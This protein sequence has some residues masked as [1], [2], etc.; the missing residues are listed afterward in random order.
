[1][2]ESTL[3]Q[4]ENHWAIWA[5]LIAVATFGLWAETTRW[6]LRVSGFVV[7][8]GTTFVLANLSIIPSTAP[9]FDLVWSYFVPLAIPLLLFKADIV[10]IVRE[11]GPMLLAYAIGAVG[12][13]LGTLLA[14]KVVPLGEHAWQLAGIFCATYVGGSMNFV[15]TAEAL[16]LH[17]SDLIAAGI[18]AD[19]LIMTLYF[20]LLLTLPTISFL[21]KTFSLRTEEDKEGDAREV[22]TQGSGQEWNALALGKAVA[23]AAVLCA[24]GFALSDLTGIKGTG[25]LFIT[26][27]VVIL[28]T[29]LPRQMGQ[30]VGA[31]QVGTFLM[32][33]FFAVI[34]ASANIGIVMRVGPKLFL[35]A[36][37]ILSVHLTFLLVAGKLLKL[38]LDEL[39]IASNA[40]MGGPTTAAAMAVARKWDALVIPAILCGTLGYAIATFVGVALAHWLR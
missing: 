13:V 25:I 22:Q 38:R 8:I 3:I 19:N 14:F 17:E 34:G 5:I 7:V 10:R 21:R 23:I 6:G 16:Q 37:L 40:N 18:A 28:A 24:V 33:I 2:P 11:A 1:M 31:D 20:I 32:Y 27:L 15:A 36:A 35:F 30:I 26:A 4:P 29:A 12:T 39:V 9:A